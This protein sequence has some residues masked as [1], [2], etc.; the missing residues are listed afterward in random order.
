MSS[1][2]IFLWICHSQVKTWRS[3]KWKILSRL[4]KKGGSDKTSKNT[5]IY[6]INS[7]ERSCLK[8]DH[9]KSTISLERCDKF[10]GRCSIWWNTRSQKRCILDIWG[11]CKIK[12]CAHMAGST[13]NI[14]FRVLCSGR[15]QTLWKL[16]NMQANEFG[17]AN[18]F[19]EHA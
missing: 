10:A 5:C 4:T 19:N 18:V 13:W 3:D 6:N 17:W 15:T 8:W 14:Y 9:N 1:V 16:Y 12:G 2:H 11:V 7:C